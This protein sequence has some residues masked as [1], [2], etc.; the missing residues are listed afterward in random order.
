MASQTDRAALAAEVC[1]A[2]R[3][4]CPG[5]SAELI[6]SLASGTADAFSDIDV[7]WVVPDAQFPDCL[8]R[9]MEALGEIQPAGGIRSDPDFHRSDRRRL[10]LVRFAGVPLFWR[11]DPGVRTASVADDLH[12]DAGNPAARAGEGEWSRPASALANAVGAVKAAARQ[13]DDEA[14][15]LLDRRFARIGEDDRATGAWV[16]NVARLARRRT[17]RFRPVRPVRPGHHARNLAP[18]QRWRLT[19]GI[20]SAPG[21]RGALYRGRPT[22][23]SPVAPLA[24]A[25]GHRLGSAGDDPVG[26]AGRQ[27][28]AALPARA[29]RDDDVFSCGGK[30]DGGEPPGGVCEIGSQPVPAR[31]RAGEA[32]S[33]VEAFYL[34]HG[35]PDA[36]V[37]AAC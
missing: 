17:A 19:R 20:P 22:A 23:R 37:R 10:L 32:Q 8:A 3:R 11:L 31:A 27:R 21:I 7:T 2:L 16:N 29:R 13:Q 24:W 18:R 34:G 4:C 25:V 9:V 6:S 33:G 15:G 30:G 26:S 14:R 5:S 1:L 36:Q 12:Y 28:P 35:R